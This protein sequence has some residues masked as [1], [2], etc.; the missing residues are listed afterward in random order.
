MIRKGISDQ[1]FKRLARLVQSQAWGGDE[2][3]GTETKHYVNAVGERFGSVMFFSDGAKAYLTG[4]AAVKYFLVDGTEVLYVEDP[5]TYEFYDG[6]WA[7]YRD[8]VPQ[9]VMTAA[10]QEDFNTVMGTGYEVVELSE[11]EAQAAVADFEGGVEFMADQNAG[12]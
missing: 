12:W 8:Y 10:D 3:V 9:G 4:G 2:V 6:V 5:E 11:E 1:G 7:E